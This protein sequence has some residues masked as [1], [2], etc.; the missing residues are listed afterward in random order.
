MKAKPPPWRRR[1]IIGT[2]VLY[3][4]DCAAIMPAVGDYDAVVSDPPYGI[5]YV[6]GAENIKHATKF[7]GIAVIGDDK[8]FDPAPFLSRPCVL[9]GANH[10]ASR[11]PGAGRWL[12]WDK[13]AGLAGDGKAMSDV[14]LAWVS[15][16][17]HADRIFRLV[18]DGFNK[19]EERGVER[20]H[21]TQKPV[22]VM[23]WSMGFLPE[24]RTV[25][26]PFMGSGTTGVA[27]VQLGRRFIGIEMD[28]GYFEIACKRI[29]DA[30]RQPRLF[31]AAPGA[32]PSPAAARPAFEF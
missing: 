12:V 10:F 20:F 6:H 2:A 14:E 3:L 8:P 13:R 5:G 19:G 9:W 32:A 24:A 18:W 25:V 4:G 17:R 31:E 26:D 23:V 21:P 28:E 11:L 30:W 16:P 22:S 7:S 1:E 15:G 29:S 27:A